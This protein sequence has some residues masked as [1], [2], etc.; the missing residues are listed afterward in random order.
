MKSRVGRAYRDAE[1]LGDAVNRQIEV[2][3]QD[4]HRSVVEGEA[5]KAALEL[6]AVDDR[7]QPIGPGRLVSRQESKV[8]CPA[9]L[10]ASLRIAGAKEDAIR[11]SLEAGRVAELRKVLPDAQQRVLRRVLGEIDVTQD[12]RATARNRS[13][14]PKARSA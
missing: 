5:A 4:H 6:V 12:P 2:V 8:R 9:T 1:Q 14:M 11:P 10:L 7:G 13:A 3:V